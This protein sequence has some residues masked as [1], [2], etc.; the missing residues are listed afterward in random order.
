MACM[1]EQRGEEAFA[2]QVLRQVLGV[3]FTKF[4]DN[5]E[6]RQVDALFTLPDGVHGALEVTTIG[7]EAAI[8]LES[9]AHRRDWTVPGARW[10]WIINVGP[11]VSLDQLRVRIDELVLTCERLGATDP[12]QIF[13]VERRSPAF[14]W[15]DEND[16]SMFGSP[17]TTRPGAIDVLP[18]GAGGA[19]FE[20]LDELPT[21]IEAMLARPEIERKLDK[22]RATGRPELHLFVRI[23]DPGMPF[24]L[25]YPLAFRDAVPTT[26]LAPP[27][28]LTGLWLGTRW[29][30]PMLRWSADIGWRREDIFG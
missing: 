27:A 25:H 13:T 16:V 26:P 28:G 8:A 4:D 19:V 6:P 3:T 15:L 10:A 7:D 2:C 18:N 20:H 30:H 24:S 29:K 1:V 22:L 23:H 12:G 11:P 14:R 5:T 21:W 9:L 17:N